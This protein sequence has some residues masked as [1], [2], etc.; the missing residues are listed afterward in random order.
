[1]TNWN[2]AD[3]EKQINSANATDKQCYETGQTHRAYGW[4]RLPSGAWNA[5]Q[6][7]FY[8]RGFDNPDR[9]FQAEE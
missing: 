3:R 7:E 2:T 1:M 6:V 9:A 4:G 8:N 5:R